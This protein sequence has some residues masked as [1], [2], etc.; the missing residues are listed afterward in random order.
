MAEVSRVEMKHE[1]ASDAACWIESVD[2]GW[3][4]LM[5]GEAHGWLIAVGDTT[6]RLLAQSRLVGEE[7][8]R[9]EP[10]QLGFATHPRISDPLCGTGLSGNRWLA[11]GTAA[12]GFDPLCGDGTGNAT[13]EAILACAVIAAITDGKA[14]ADGALTHYRARLQAGF[15]RHLEISREFYR[16]GGEGDWWAEQVTELDR[17]IAWCRK[18]LATVTSFSYRLKDFDLERLRL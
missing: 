17:G 8:A 15:Q 13:R 7:I 18:Q 9:I 10:A 4:F 5:P 1:E 14:D 6:E 16:T 11:C 2:A 3:L 12:L